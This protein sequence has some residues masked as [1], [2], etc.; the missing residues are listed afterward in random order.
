VKAFNTVG[1]EMMADPHPAP[2]ATSMLV[3]GDDDSAKQVVIT[4]AREI[5]FE[6]CDAGTLSIA[7][8]LEPLGMLW[9][10]LCSLRGMGPKFAFTIVPQ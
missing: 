3:C 4:L 7:R 8:L 9:I 10:H 5:G 1:W 2:N 6:P